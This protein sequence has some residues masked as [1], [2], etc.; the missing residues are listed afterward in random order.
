M[1][2]KHRYSLRDDGGLVPH[3][4]EYLCLL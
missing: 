4:N 2:A 3:E 1:N